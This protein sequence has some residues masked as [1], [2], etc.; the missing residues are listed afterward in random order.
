MRTTILALLTMLAFLP[1]MAWSQVIPSDS[2]RIILPDSL[3]EKI[4]AKVPTDEEIS[5]Q[6]VAWLYGEFPIS[7]Q[8]LNLSDLNRKSTGQEPSA[9]L[10]ETPGITA[11]SDAGN[12]QG[13]SYI[14]IRGI[15]QTRINVSLDG[16]P[17]NE[18]E[19]QGAYFSNFPDMFN[20]VSRVIVERG[21]GIN[22]NGT[23]SYGG[24]IRMTTPRLTGQR[25]LEVG[26]GYGSF[27]ST[28]AYAEYQ[29]NSRKGWT[30]YGRGSQIYS[31]GYKYRSSNN[32][33]SIYLKAKK[34]F[35]KSSLEM[36]VLGGFQ[37][38][39]LAWLGVRDSLIEI[40]RRTNANSDE[41][42]RFFQGLASLNYDH[43]VGIN[44]LASVQAYYGQLTGGYDFDLNNFLGLPSTNEMYRYD[45]RSHLLGMMYSHY[46]QGR[47]FEFEGKAF[48]N[49]YRRNHIGSE[50][51]LGELYSNAG[52]K[53]EVSAT[54]QLR[55]SLWKFRLFLDTQL[56]H[57]AFGYRGNVEMSPLSWTFLNPKAGF[58][59][60]LPKD[61]NLYYSFGSTGR[62]PTR[63]DMF[64]GSDDLLA[65]SLGNPLLFIT[66][67][68]RVFDHE[69][70]F[71]KSGNRFVFSLNLYYM[72]FRNEIVL[73]GKFGPNGLALTNAVDLSYRAGVEG[74]MDVRIGKHLRLVHNSAFNRSR[75]R[76][77]GVTFAPVLTPAW[78]LNQEAIFNWNRW[79]FAASARFQSSSW[80]DFANSA[81]IQPYALLNARVHY[82]LKRLGL[83]LY[84]NNLTN[85]KYYNNGYVDWDGSRK[86]F[87]QAPI[88]FYG[89]IRYTF[90]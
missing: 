56:R 81:S 62:E 14:R 58:V 77:Q 52:S 66:Q 72:D 84:A 31:S 3:L 28:R 82:D 32:S 26:L 68:E 45:F 44:G 18:P 15:D 4:R 7:L 76:E 86:L 38:N 27:N 85:A 42:D 74:S 2:T 24:S 78:I 22:K 90:K 1:T 53:A 79:T 33:Q 80:I 16:I 64:G 43:S 54:A 10:Q 60:S 9:I 88:N 63:N 20:S 19:D 25:K 39:R 21:V 59:L 69:L 70:G 36:D 23:A 73:N 40:D 67:P 51:S 41:R 55:Y 61:L 12:P 13:Y 65:D 89:A 71:R 37:R 5:V 30:F 57:V 49:V 35:D 46:L 87:V 29:S 83:S 11:Y 6:I 47:K 8:I 48:G 17:L 34:V 50:R 75:I